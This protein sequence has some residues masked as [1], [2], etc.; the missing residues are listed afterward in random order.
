MRKV[1]IARHAERLDGVD[2]TWKPRA[3]CP[4]DTP[5]SEHGHEQA[6]ELAKSMK[7]KEIAHVIC[8]PFLRTRQTAG[9]CARE[10]GLKIKIELGLHEWINIPAKVEIGPVDWR[11]VDTRYEPVWKYSMQRESMAEMHQRMATVAKGL[12]KLEGNLLLISHGDPVRGLILAYSGSLPPMPEVASVQ[13][14]E[15]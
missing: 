3:A 5:L 14:V 8:S 12:L 7:D 10:L 9:Y 4:H 15:T 2:P 1:W 13:A 6:K 11:S